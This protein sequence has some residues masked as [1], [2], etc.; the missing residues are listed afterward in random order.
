MKSSAI[1]AIGTSALGLA[2]CMVATVTGRYVATAQPVDLGLR[3][4]TPFC[5]AVDAGDPQG[6][7]WWEPGA[8]GCSSRS[9]GPTV[10]RA[11]AAA[12]T[13]SGTTIDARFRIPLITGPNPT[14]PDHKD[15]A[16]V[17]DGGRL[18]VPAT[19]ADVAIVQRNDL[20]VPE[21]V[22]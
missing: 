22:R 4:G 7:W 5:I 10:F 21:R 11:D 16:L 17:I 20:E 19:G 14:D 1:L 2:A 13:T 12:V 3:G 8:T 6:V 15:V 18:R 9:T